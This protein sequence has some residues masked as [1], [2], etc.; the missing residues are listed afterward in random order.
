MQ[1]AA[2]CTCSLHG[3]QQVAA[4]TSAVPVGGLAI[5]RVDRRQLRPGI[6]HFT[7]FSGRRPVAER[8]YFRRPTRA[9]L[10]T[11]AATADQPAY[12]PRQPVA[13]R[14]AAAAPAQ[15][16]LAVYRLDS[17]AA[18]APAADMASY[19]LLVADLPGY[20]EDAGYYCRDSSATARRAADNLMLT[21]GWRRF[22]WDDVLAPGSPPPPAYPPELNGYQ[23]QGRVS[24][25]SGAA[26][27][28]TVAYLSLPGRAFQ[29]TNALS[30]ADGRVQFELP[31]F[32]G[33]RKLVLQTNPS[34]ADSTARVEL[35]KPLRG[36]GRRL[37]RAGAGPAAGALGG[38]AL[39]AALAGAGA[40]G[41]PAPAPQLRPAPGDTVAFY[42]KPDEQ[43]FLDDLHPLPD[44]GGRAARVCAR[45]AGAQAPRWLP[46]PGGGPPPSPHAKR[47][48]ADAARWSAYLQYQ[49][50]NGL[51]PAQN[52]AARRD[53]EPLFSGLPALRWA[54]ELRHVPGR[55]GRLS[56]QP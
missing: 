51:R 42:G 49:P 16:S 17:L 45:R 38:F 5:F 48:S 29:F 46:L 15:A 9:E 6:T 43:F 21:Q 22:R 56:A 39:R 50:D 1:P 19:L 13:L 3:G 37:G 26:R 34:T 18:G 40:G 14:L 25:P 44:R 11:L 33:L 7:V 23:L 55:P 54:S 47:E 53:G 35:A 31:D 24:G 20:V 4:V 30:R 2:R 36:G 12:G 32:Y 27:P 41:L 52:Q 28:G 10:L 8:L